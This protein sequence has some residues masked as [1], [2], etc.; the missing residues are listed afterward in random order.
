LDVARGLGCQVNQ[1]IWNIEATEEEKESVED[2][3]AREGVVKDTKIIALAPGTNWA[4]KCWAPEKYAEVAEALHKKYDII[5][6]I[7]GGSKD[8]ELARTIKEKCNRAIDLCGKTTLKQLSY[9][10]QK[11][12]LFIG[13]DTGPMHLAVSMNTPVIALFGPTDPKRNGPYGQENTVIQSGSECS[14][15]FKRQCTP[16]KCMEAITVEEVL[17]ASKKYCQNS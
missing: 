17:Q 10:L 11:S 2:I 3:L 13:G 5:S 7:I 1:P 6:V 8:G 14:P 16:L 4:S 15:C 12:A 9:V